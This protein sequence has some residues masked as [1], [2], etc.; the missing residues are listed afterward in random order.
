MDNNIIN[1]LVFGVILIAFG[2]FVRNPLKARESVSTR[3]SLCILYILLGLGIGV[4]AAGLIMVFLVS[5]YSYAEVMSLGRIVILG[6]IFL[7][8]ICGAL[9]AYI[10]PIPVTPSASEE[11]GLQKLAEAAEAA[12]NVPPEKTS[13]A[14][15]IVTLILCA[16]IF[17]LNYFHGIYN[18]TSPDNYLFIMG[19]TWLAFVWGIVSLLYVVFKRMKASR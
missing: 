14:P 13:F 6:G 18:D 8:A 9:F 3:A 12:K 7:G 1:A 10:R 11:Q 4:V 15:S 19:A 2:W 16:G 5:K 17:A